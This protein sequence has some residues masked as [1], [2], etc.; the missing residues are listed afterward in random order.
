VALERPA[1]FLA[2]RAG[3]AVAGKLLITDW[4]LRIERQAAGN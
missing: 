1:E 2:K 4:Q 3:N